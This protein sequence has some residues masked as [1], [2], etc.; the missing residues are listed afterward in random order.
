M[1]DDSD[2]NEHS[3]TCSQLLKGLTSESRHILDPTSA[4]PDFVALASPSVLVKSE[5]RGGTAIKVHTG[6][7]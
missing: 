3:S 2:H 4:Y 7:L 5:S 6:T 1:I